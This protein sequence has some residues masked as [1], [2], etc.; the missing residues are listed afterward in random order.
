MKN[1]SYLNLDK[2]FE[3]FRLLVCNLINMRPF[4]AIFRGFTFVWRNFA[5]RN[6]PLFEGSFI[7]CK[8]SR[9][10]IW[11][12]HINGCFCNCNFTS[13]VL[14]MPWPFMVCTNRKPLSRKWVW[15]F[16]HAVNVRWTFYSQQAWFSVMHFYMYIY[17][18]DYTY[19]CA[20][21]CVC[22]CVCGWVG[23]CVCI[24]GNYEQLN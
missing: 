14:L 11:R 8:I 7:V 4:L 3:S 17:I 19:V 5:E 18:I 2:F 15:V 9:T 23:G 16:G 6:Q 1:R 24:H 10:G 13:Y 22:V 21:E 12:T 20:C